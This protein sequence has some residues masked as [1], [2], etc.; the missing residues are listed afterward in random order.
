ML[1]ICQN[2]MFQVHEM[3]SKAFR[4]MGNASSCLNVLV[5]W[6]IAKWLVLSIQVS[7]TFEILHI[8]AVVEISWKLSDSLHLSDLFRYLCW[9]VESVLRNI[10]LLHEWLIFIAELGIFI[11]SGLCNLSYHSVWFLY[12]DMTRAASTTLKCSYPS[13]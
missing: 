10:V 2:F 8:F 3:H 13:S 11:W 1:K 5:N 4:V 12:N 6:E 7:I 9:K